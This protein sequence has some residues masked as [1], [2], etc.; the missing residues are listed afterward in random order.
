MKRFIMLVAA[1]TIAIP[2][3]AQNVATVNRKPI[4]Q[5]SLDQFIKL[6]VSQGAT[7]TPD[8]REK[9][10]EE[11]I[12][13]EVLVQAAEKEG[14]AKQPDVASEI[15]LARQTAL[16]RA[17]MADYL[18]KH[19]V[20]D[21]QVQAEY[22]KLKQQQASTMEYE[23]RHIL[24]ED[25]KTAKNL[26]AELKKDKRKFES[27]AKKYSK[28]PGSAEKGGKLGWAPPSNYVQPFAQ[29]VTQL[30]KGELADNPVQTQF[31][32]HVIMV[33]NI[34]PLEFPSLDQA[35][36]QIEEMLRRQT[37]ADYQKSLREKAK[38]EIKP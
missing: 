7:D 10:K 26:L 13:R 19:P 5:Q 33:D 4:T 22:N 14:V 3:F 8:L 23:V 38:I 28:D 24:V 32:W 34:R 35:R 6:L 12:N 18:Q 29:A 37:L 30:K 16:V 25:E 9:V 21:A 17:L 11:M 31:G 36:P 2:A 20:T 27:L 1:C 15:E